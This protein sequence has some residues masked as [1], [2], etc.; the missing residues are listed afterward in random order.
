M[1]K[2]TVH[3]Q[4][5]PLLLELKPSARL[6]QGI[7][8]IHLIAA[9]AGIYNALAVTIQISVFTAVAIHLYADIKRLKDTSVK[10]KYSEMTDWEISEADEQFASVQ[11]LTTTVITSF[12]MILHYRHESILSPKRIKTLLIMND[13]LSKNDFRRLLVSLKTT[14][15]K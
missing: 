5:T 1:T 11:I 2:L 12:V 3:K 8:L 6:K 9:V 15:N 13:S 4:P 14:K 7:I 10:I